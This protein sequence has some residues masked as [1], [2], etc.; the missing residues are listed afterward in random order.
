MQMDQDLVD[1]DD[2]DFLEDFLLSD[3]V[4]DEAM[5]LSELDGY[6][7]AIATGPKLVPPSEWLP[8]IW[9]GAEPDFADAEEARRVMAAI[10]GRYNEIL[11]TL[12]RAPLELEP[13]FDYDLD[14][15]VFPDIWATGFLTGVQLREAAW[16]PI[17]HSTHATAFSVIAAL[18]APEQMHGLVSDPDDVARLAAAFAEELP[19]TIAAIDDFWK[20]RR[21]YSTTGNQ[22]PAKT[23][24][25]EPCPCGSGKK[26]KKCCGAN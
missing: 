25:N 9:R 13:L 2:L 10:M 17:H 5:L 24:R 12:A 20:K 21:G 1:P 7:T 4:S 15:T 3:A 11:A 23:G 22:R 6:L 8:E 18:A 16:T 19:I 26:F 14:G